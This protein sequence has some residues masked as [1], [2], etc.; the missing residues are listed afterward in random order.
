MSMRWV[1]A[2][3]LRNHDTPAILYRHEGTG[4]WAAPKDGKPDYGAHVAMQ[5]TRSG[6][7]KSEIVQTLR[8]VQQGLING[9]WC[10]RQRNSVSLHGFSFRRRLFQNLKYGQRPARRVNNAEVSEGRLIPMPQGKIVGG[11]NAAYLRMWMPENRDR[12]GQ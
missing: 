6:T 11:F 8:Y 9:L 1:I 2:K 3:S 5:V 12:S 4:L 7:H 10:I